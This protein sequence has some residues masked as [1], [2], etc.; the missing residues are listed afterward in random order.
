MLGEFSWLGRIYQAR[1]VFDLV[2]FMET[3]FTPS[4]EQCIE[5]RI[6]SFHSTTG[7]ILVAIQE[8]S[9]D[10]IGTDIQCYPL[11]VSVEVGIGERIVLLLLTSY[12]VDL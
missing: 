3:P 8:S 11:L 6:T 9:R 1:M 10:A 7:S 12:L 5:L 4:I 2:N